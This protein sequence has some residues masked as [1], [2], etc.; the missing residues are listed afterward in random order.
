MT[1]PLF[2]SFF[3]TQERSLQARLL[4]LARLQVDLRQPDGEGEEVRY[5][6]HLP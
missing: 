4:S 1:D 6:S 5:L 2:P 3:Q